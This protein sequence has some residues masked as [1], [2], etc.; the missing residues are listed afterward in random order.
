MLPAVAEREYGPEC[1]L[2]WR[3]SIAA[4]IWKDLSLLHA[5]MEGRGPGLMGHISHTQR[6]RLCAVSASGSVQGISHT[7]GVAVRCGCSIQ[8]P[9]SY[10][11]IYS[12]AGDPGSVGPYHRHRRQLCA[13]SAYR[14]SISR[15]ES[16]YEK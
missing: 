15:P 13:V 16:Y 14:H 8:G 6:K 4:L 1:P 12:R 11:C 3:W 10:S 5:R 2:C 9:G 7:W